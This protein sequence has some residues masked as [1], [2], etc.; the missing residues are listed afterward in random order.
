MSRDYARDSQRNSCTNNNIYLIYIILLHNVMAES[1]QWSGLKVQRISCI[2]NAKLESKGA[3][4]C[5]VL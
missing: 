2:E 1:M 3:E 4:D 5:F